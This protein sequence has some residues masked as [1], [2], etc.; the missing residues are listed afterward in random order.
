MRMSRKLPELFEAVGYYEENDGLAEYKASKHS[1]YDGLKRMSLDELLDSC[2]AVLVE[3]TV[4]DLTKYAKV[5]VDAGKHIHMDKPASGT[6][7][8]FKDMLDTAKSKGLVVQMGYMY[9]NNP[10]VGKCI[11]AVK[12][13][14]LGE[15]YSVNAE[16]STFH[17]PD[18]KLRLSS[19]E[20]AP[21]IL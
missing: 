5:C 19:Y 8:E 14:A 20:A 3:S 15:I 11:E 2:D 18:T 7:E 10:A 13:G 6:L 16:I 1:C 21:C 9:R 17:R 12:S 4:N